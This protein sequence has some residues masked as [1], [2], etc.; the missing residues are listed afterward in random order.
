MRDFEHSDQRMVRTRQIMNTK[1]ITALRTAAKALDEETF[2]Y[3]WSFTSTCNCGSLCCALL[4]KSAAEMVKLIPKD[5]HKVGHVTWTNLVG[6]YCPISG[7]P[8]NSL[9]C[10]LVRCGLTPKL[11]VELE[12][13]S[14][15]EILA[16]IRESD[17][18]RLRSWWQLGEVVIDCEDRRHVALYMRAW[19]EL[20]TEQ[21][22][23]SRCAV[24][25]T[26]RFYDAVDHGR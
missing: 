19:A 2:D 6:Q 25:Q 11:I 12:N 26:N 8:A 9:F 17:L 13:L 16:R 18:L 21:G 4:G 20:L 24:T 7:L 1:L 15:P 22:R 5:I 3:D 14:N 23:T 10:E